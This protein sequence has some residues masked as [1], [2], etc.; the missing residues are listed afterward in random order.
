MEKSFEKYKF[1]TKKL[2]FLRS[3]G[4][5]RIIIYIGHNLGSG[6]EA[7]PKLGK[8]SIILSKNLIYKIENLPNFQ[9]FD[10]FS[11]I[12]LKN[13]RLP[14]TFCCARGVRGQSLQRLRLFTIFHKYFTSTLNF[15][16]HNTRPPS[17]PRVNFMN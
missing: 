5:M 17:R 13:K 6:A 14:V 9:H 3:V 4:K 1:L 15:F 16:P 12:S 11:Q 7:P 8:F 10:D 2:H